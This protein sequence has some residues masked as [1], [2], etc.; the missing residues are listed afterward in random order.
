[1]LSH[2]VPHSRGQFQSLLA[3]LQVGPG[4]VNDLRKVYDARCAVGRPVGPEAARNTLWVLIRKRPFQTTLCTK[5]NILAR[6]VGLVV[7]GLSC[8]A[9][10]CAFSKRA[11]AFE[12]SGDA[13]RPEG[14]AA[15]SDAH[16]D[17]KSR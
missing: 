6:A 2:R 11:V 5:W 9:I 13:D 16:A 12:V 4:V 1:M 8:A 3:S 10:S 15:N 7:R 14:M 17:I